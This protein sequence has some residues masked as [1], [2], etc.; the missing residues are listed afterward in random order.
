MFPSEPSQSR[1][2]VKA[3][4]NSDPLPN[5]L[6]RAPVERGI[7]RER[8][9]DLQQDGAVVDQF[10]VL[11]GIGDGDAIRAR[12]DGLLRGPDGDRHER[13]A[14]SQ[15]DRQRKAASAR[16]HAEAPQDHF[17]AQRG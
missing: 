6:V 14:R 7:A 13:D 5:R 3:Y 1:H 8:V 4:S 11:F 12:R 16:H 17:F 2:A 10:R 9:P 15:Q